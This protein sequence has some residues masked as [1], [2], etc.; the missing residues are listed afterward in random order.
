PDDRVLAGAG[1]RVLRRPTLRAAAG[2][3]SLPSLAVDYWLPV[4]GQRRAALLHLDVPLLA[5]VP[6][7][8]ALCDAIALAAR[9]EDD[10]L[11]SAGRPPVA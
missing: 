9:F 10:G 7:L 3:A 1:S 8:L 2:A 4:P 6:L 11:P 5:P